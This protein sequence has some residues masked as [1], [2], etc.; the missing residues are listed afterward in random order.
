MAN[1][2]KTHHDG[3]HAFASTLTDLMTS[4]AV[5]FILLLVVFL[6]QAHD[7]AKKT[8]NEVREQLGDLLE[9]KSLALT[10]DPDDPLTLAVAVDE[11]KLRFPLGKYHLSPEGGVFVDHF[12][13]NFSQKICK[14]DLRNK[15]DSVVIQGHTDRSG[16]RT[17]EGVRDNIELSQKRS[18][19]VLERS[20]R[21]VQGDPEAYECLLKRVSASGRGSRSPVLVEGTYNADLSRRV[22]IKI[23]VRSTEQQFKEMLNKPVQPKKPQEQAQPSTDQSP[24]TVS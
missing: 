5:I 23:R 22:E 14:T 20:L 18:F 7:Q 10:Q 9:Q 17:P 12:F 21:S 19:A 3:T 4:L 16:E 2:G 24:Q 15:I 1:G 6:K 8:K 11:S 13:R